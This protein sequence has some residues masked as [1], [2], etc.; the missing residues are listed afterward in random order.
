M[1]NTGAA[2]R[3]NAEEPGELEPHATCVA[4]ARFRQTS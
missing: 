3:L 1:D 4:S 2:T